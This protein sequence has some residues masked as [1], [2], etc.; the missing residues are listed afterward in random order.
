ML[1]PDSFIRQ[2]GDIDIYVDGGKDSVI[3]LLNSL[4]LLSKED[5][6]LVAYHHVHLEQHDNS[7]IMIEVHFLPSSGFYNPFSNKRLQNFLLEEV[8]YSQLCELGFYV[9]T[10]KFALAMQLAHIQGHFLEEGIGLRQIIDYYFL[11]K[12][13]SQ[14]DR[15]EISAMLDKFGVNTFTSALMYIFKEMF[16]LDESLMLC[17]PNE[18][19][20]KKLL[21]EIL[22]YGNFGWFGH[23]N[24]YKNIHR[25]VYRKFHSFRFL[26]FYL[27]EFHWFLLYSV[28]Y[29]IQRIPLRIKYKT[30]SLETVYLK[31]K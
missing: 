15:N 12:N 13:S 30:W 24:N 22:S 25:S 9:P 16:M 18:K 5:E 19:K 8:K 29:F 31:S 1:Y 26:T 7:D 20:G 14:D 3:K 23:G 6:D 17:K 4:N 2:P 21:N 28:V 10:M 11:L 27:H